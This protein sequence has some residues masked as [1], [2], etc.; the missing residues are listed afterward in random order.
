[1]EC[2]WRCVIL[3]LVLLPFGLL[4]FRG[5]ILLEAIWHKMYVGY[6]YENGSGQEIWSLQVHKSFAADLKIH[7]L[8]MFLLFYSLVKLVREGLQKW[9]WKL[10]QIVF[11]N[12]SLQIPVC[13]WKSL[14]VGWLH[15][16]AFQVWNLTNCRLKIN[17]SGHTGY[18][19]TVTV[20]PD[21]SL[22]ASGGKVKRH[23][24]MQHYMK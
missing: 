22:C 8:K 21:G 20:S 14:L 6:K 19:N 17:H 23:F 3:M 18:L 2:F 11:A 12:R 16:F 13:V 4:C 5:G 7:L 24:L 9:T 1:M 15:L 10:H